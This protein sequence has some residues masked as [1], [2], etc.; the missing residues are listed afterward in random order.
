LA[1]RKVDKQRAGAPKH[2]H[3]PVERPIPTLMENR[4]EVAPIDLTLLARGCLKAHGQFTQ[5]AMLL[6]QRTQ[7]VAQDRTSS[8]IALGVDLLIQTHGRELRARGEPVLQVR[9]ERIQLRAAW[10]RPGIL[11]QAITAERPAHGVAVNAQL[12]SDS[13]NRQ[14]LLLQAFDHH[15]YLLPDHP[16]TPFRVEIPGRLSQ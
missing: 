11:R 13:A 6:A 9:F 15:P 14:P 5:A 1:G 7:K 12:A 10:S 3:K 2:H 8:R 16:G 4:L